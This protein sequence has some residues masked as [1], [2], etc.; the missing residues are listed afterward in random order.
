MNQLLSLA[1]GPVVLATCFFSWELTAQT[2]PCADGCGLAFSVE[3][4]DS[5][6]ECPEELP[7]DCDGLYALY[8]VDGVTVANTCSGEEAALQ[9]CFPMVSEA[10]SQPVTTCAATTAK[11]DATLGDGE[12]GATDGALRIYGLSAMGLADSDYFV[13]SVDNPLTFEHTPDSRSARLTG[14]VHCVLNENQIFHVDARF[15]NEDN[16]AEWLAENPLNALLIADDPEVPGY[17]PCAVDTAAISVFD[18]QVMSR[19]VGDGEYDGT[20]FID[21][22]PMSL[23]KRFQLGEGANN[24]N[25]NHGL[26]G[27]FRWEGTLNGQDVAGL[28]GDI[29]VDLACGSAESAC[30]EYAEFLLEGWDECGFLVSQTVRIDRVDTQ[31]PEVVSGAEDLVVSCDAVPPMAAPEDLVTT[32][33]C[34]GDVLVS[35]G[36][37]LLV[38]GACPQS[39]QLERRW[40]LTDACGNTSVHIQWVTVQD[41]EAPVL[42]ADSAIEVACGQWPDATVYATATDNCG[43]VSISFVD[44]ATAGGCVLP[45]GQFVRTY[46]ATDECGNSSTLDQVITLTDDEAP[47]FTAVPADYTASCDDELPLEMATATDNCSGAT[48]AVEETVVEGDCPNAWTVVRTYTATDNCGNAATAVQTIEV[49]DVDAPVLV[50]PADVTFECG[51]T[52]VEAEATATDNCGEV[53]LGVT[54]EVVPGACAGSYQIVRTFTAIDACGNASSGVQTITVVDTTA[55]TFLT[56]PADYTAECSEDLTLDM[57]TAEDICGEVVVSVATEEVLGPCPQSYQVVRTFT[58]TDDCGNASEAVQVITVVDTTGPVFGFVPADYTAEC[59]D[60]HP[61]EDATATDNCGAVTVAVT[62]DTTAGACP[63]AFTV[64]RTFTATDECGNATQAVQVIEVVDTTAPV[65]EWPAEVVL[66]CENYPTDEVFATATDNCDGAVI[67]FEDTPVSGGCVLPHGAYIRTYTAVDACGNSTTAEQILTLVDDVAPVF[68]FVPADLTVACTDTPVLEAATAT[69][70]CSEVEMTFAVDT[71]WGACEGSYEVV[72]TWTAS[73]QCDNTAVATQVITVEDLEAPVFTIVPADY[74]LEC[75]EEPVFDEAYAIDNCSSLT[76]MEDLEVLEGGC[77]ATYTL[78]RTIT[79]EDACGNAS[80]I[81]QTITVVDL[82]APTFT[83]VPADAVVECSEEPVYEDATAEDACSDFDIVLA[84]DTVT[85]SCGQVY[86]IV[87]TWTATDACGNSSQAVQ[88][89]SVVD[90]TAPQLLDA[91]GLYNGEVV[92]VC[93]EA[94]DGTLTLPAA[95]SLVASDNCQGDPEVVLTETYI[96]AFAP[97]DEVARW[98]TV[99]DP[100]ALATGET[101]D[102]F[103]PHSMHLFNFPGADF[104]NTVDGTVAHNVDGTMTYTLEVVASNNPNAGWSLELHYSEPLTWEE[105]IAQP[106]AQSYKSD[107]GLGDHTTWH[108]AL[109]TEGTATGWGDYEGSSLSLMHQPA[110]GYFGFQIGEGANNKNANYGFSGWFYL[111]GTF[112]GASV[113]SS[114][115]VFGELDCCLPWTLE[116]HYTVSDC[117]GNETTFAYE[118]HATGEAC[119]VDAE[120][121]VE[122]EQDQTLVTPK[123]LIQIL[124]LQ[125]NPAASE[126]QFVL[127]AE[128]VGPSVTVALFTLAGTEVMPIYQ[129]EL[130]AGW[131]TPVTFDASGLES[132]MYQVRLTSKNFVTSK[133]L[134]VVH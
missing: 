129:G 66:S 41:L 97:T 55:P 50:V 76:L 21:H 26:G 75:T 102:N 73:D 46:T 89:L 93:C 79:A 51:E 10:V 94:L 112:Q 83:F 53:T 14:T 98:C 134:L 63:Q 27:W 1:L 43:S 20:L 78:L 128:E 65:L 82:S 116:R 45:E 58:A 8:G 68:G 3:L 30:D 19:L 11:R 91:C 71:L 121:G 123:D 7:V 95:C 25:C 84:V 108:Y 34:E 16:A 86:D 12:Y 126:V 127:L 36:V 107:C 105:W 103:A 99:S 117:A 80:S 6:V 23:S 113:M 125:P 54:S 5:T 35:E 115:D 111:T 85:S 9:A 77:E 15:I 22:M 47:E 2:D 118:V 131:P 88:T 110:N 92:E 60:A 37:E 29:V 133:K 100:E 90:T 114:G 132:G 67:T 49:V 28:S 52:V 33:N 70:N 18:L 42:E 81:V 106:G 62:A 72:R 24:H 56:V 40:T 87:R 101:C 31:A 61:L 44:A 124:G 122:G 4:D 59:S 39:Y 119:T 32:D 48:V 96:G 64:T 57:A 104:Y 17:A 130:I 74:T 13:E 109:M 38:E 120:D 69:D